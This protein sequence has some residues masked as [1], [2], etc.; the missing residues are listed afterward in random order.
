MIA[1]SLARLSQ[2]SLPGGEAYRRYT[3]MPMPTRPITPSTSPTRL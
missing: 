3:A 2:V 1:S